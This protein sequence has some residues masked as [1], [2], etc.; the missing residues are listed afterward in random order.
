MATDSVFRPKVRRAHVLE[1]DPDLGVHIPA[2]T[3]AIAAGRAVADLE[4]FAWIGPWEDDFESIDT[5]GHLGL[6]IVDGILARRITVGHRSGLEL[7]GPGD[8]LRPW[9]RSEFAFTDV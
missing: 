6:L 3:Y 8:V 1:L 4:T 5:D 9:V 7:L 2:E